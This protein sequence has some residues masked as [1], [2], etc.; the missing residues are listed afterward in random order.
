M[1]KLSR[2]ELI[3]VSGSAIKDQ[4]ADKRRGNSGATG[5]YPWSL[6][7]WICEPR[8]LPISTRLA[9]SVR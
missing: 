8:Y 5:G 9:E 4:V 2:L 3:Y 6:D 1:E 7:L